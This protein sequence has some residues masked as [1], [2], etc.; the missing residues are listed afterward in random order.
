MLP[1]QGTGF[2]KVTNIS[3][4]CAGFLSRLQISCLWLWWPPFLWAVCLSLPK[5]NLL[6]GR[7]VVS[8]LQRNLQSCLVASKPDTIKR[9]LCLWWCVDVVCDSMAWLFFP[10][11]SLH[12]I[13]FC[14]FVLSEFVVCGAGFVG[15]GWGCAYT[16]CVVCVHRVRLRL[17]LKRACVCSL[18]VCSAVSAVTTSRSTSSPA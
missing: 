7:C 13:V 5:R 18:F 4:F 16:L 2:V 9:D 15:F 8:P 11:P 3:V 12:P 1:V 17:P 14:V 6:F 10:T